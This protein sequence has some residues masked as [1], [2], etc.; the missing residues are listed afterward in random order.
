MSA[1]AYIPIYTSSETSQDI[2]SLESI[3]VDARQNVKVSESISDGAACLIL[4]GLQ[5]AIMSC[6][7]LSIGLYFA[8]IIIF[9]D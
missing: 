7:I 9:G 5:F 6:A 8:S 1:C 2:L 3:D 4:P